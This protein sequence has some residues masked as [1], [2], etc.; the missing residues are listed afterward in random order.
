MSRESLRSVLDIVEDP[1][2]FATAY[3]DH[4]ATTGERPP[5][6]M[7]AYRFAKTGRI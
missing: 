5:V 4:V 3:V 1:H 7:A 6:V 2:E